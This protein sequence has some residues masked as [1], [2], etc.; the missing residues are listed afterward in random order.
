VHKIGRTTGWTQGSVRGTCV[1]TN[2]GG[3]DI[4]QL[5]QTWVSA[6]ARGGDS[7]S[8]VFRRQGTGSNVTLLG[9][10]WGG[11]SLSDGTTLYIYSP[12]SNIESELGALTTF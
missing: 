9:V 10:L 2:V 1:N 3:T 6:F 5:C 12:I 4:T 7:G 8:P 11:S